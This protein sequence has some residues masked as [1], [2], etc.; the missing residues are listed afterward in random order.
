M[1][2][3]SPFNIRDCKDLVKIV[4]EDVKFEYIEDEIARDF[5]EKLLQKDAKMRLEIDEVL[6]HPFLS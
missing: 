4:N 5:V 3:E 2:G 1:T 6:L